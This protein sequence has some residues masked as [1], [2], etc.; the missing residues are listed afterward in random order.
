MLSLFPS[1]LWIFG[2]LWEETALEK[3]WEEPQRVISG[4]NREG[5][6]AIKE[7]NL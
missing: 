7:Q 5:T 3:L 6:G 1:E 2:V 4:M